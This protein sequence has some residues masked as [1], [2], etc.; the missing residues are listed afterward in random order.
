[1][2]RRE[3]HRFI[4]SK[5]LG[6]LSQTDFDTWYAFA[7]AERS[8]GDDDDDEDGLPFSQFVTVPRLALLSRLTPFADDGARA[9][10]AGA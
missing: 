1:V 6:V 8:R 5:L 9:P 2:S 7:R 3:V 10:Q 4:T